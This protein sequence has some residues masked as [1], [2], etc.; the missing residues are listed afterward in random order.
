MTIK[1]IME[2]TGLSKSTVTRGIK[3]IYPFSIEKGKKTNLTKQESKIVIMNLK[4]RGIFKDNQNESEPVQNESVLIQNEP[5]KF[6]LAIESMNNLAS[7]I[8]AQVKNQD[9]RIA[10]L[11]GKFQKRIDA[12]P[13]PVI[14]VR[15]EINRIVRD[16]VEGSG[17]DYRDVWHILY[18]DFNYRMGRSF[19]VCAKNR[20]M[21]TI[22]YIESEG[23]ISEL[24]ATARELFKK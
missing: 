23:Y 8:F 1:E 6:M 10:V 11:E 16:E 24:L 9:S 13:S 22:D 20:Q 3:D 5:D 12:L 7:A 14:S 21:K 19:S 18:S 2:L 15:N 4:K 17:S